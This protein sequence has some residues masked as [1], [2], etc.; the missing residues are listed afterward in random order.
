M[1]AWSFFLYGRERAGVDAQVP[2]PLHHP[3][4]DELRA[5]YEV[6]AQDRQR[7]TVHGS[8]QGGD[9]E[10][11]RR[12]L[13]IERVKVH[14]VSTSVVFTV[15]VGS[16]LRVSPQWATVTGLEKTRARPRASPAGLADLD[17]A[18]KVNGL[19]LVVDL[20]RS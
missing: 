15:R 16:L 12:R 5:A 17:G 10:S 11:C 3:V 4:V 1:V 20:P 6:H 19:A 7:Q 18:A 2:D 8:V 9:N 14:S 13:R